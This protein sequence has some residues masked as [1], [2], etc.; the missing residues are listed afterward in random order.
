[1]ILINQD[2]KRQSRFLSYVDYSDHVLAITVSL[3]ERFE[4]TV[5]CFKLT[6]SLE[7]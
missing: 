7:T 4:L 5:K 1:M 2:A 6:V 3:Y